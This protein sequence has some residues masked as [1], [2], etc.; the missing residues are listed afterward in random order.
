[1]SFTEVGVV[2]C[3]YMVSPQVPRFALLE[4]CHLLFQIRFE[5]RRTLNSETLHLYA[6]VLLPFYPFLGYGQSHWESAISYP[7]HEVYL[8]KLRDCIREC[9]LRKGVSPP[10]VPCLYL[11][12]AD[13]NCTS[14]MG[15]LQGFK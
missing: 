15:L 9:K 3:P 13:H 2:G 4:L 5:D 7:K 12:I 14:L 8:L 6:P 11:K 10:R 1:M